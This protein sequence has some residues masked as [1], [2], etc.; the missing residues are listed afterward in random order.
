MLQAFNTRDDIVERILDLMQHARHHFRKD[1]HL[2]AGNV[3]WR[4]GLIQGLAQTDAG[5]FPR[6]LRCEHHIIDQPNPVA[7][8]RWIGAED[9]GRE[10]WKLLP[11]QLPGCV[12][13]RAFAGIKQENRARIL[14]KNVNQI[15]QR[16][17]LMEL[18]LAGLPTYD[19]HRSIRPGSLE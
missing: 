18:G 11:S 12:I 15:S 7:G 9:D 14:G 17:E 4:S 3:H 10:R 8:A 13:R 16:F 2:G 6:R 1:H 5:L 19:W